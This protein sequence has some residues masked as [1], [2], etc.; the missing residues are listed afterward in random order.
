MNIYNLEKYTNKFKDE[1]ARYFEDV[2]DSM[3][4]DLLTKKIGMTPAEAKLFLDK[5]E[6]CNVRF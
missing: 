5:I 1:G 4:S 6:Q 2:L 3:D